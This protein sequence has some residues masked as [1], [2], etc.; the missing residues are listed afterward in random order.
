MRILHII[1][2]IDISGGGPSKSVSDLAFTQAM[3]GVKATIFTN[4]SAN[5]YLKE[6]P[7]PNLQLVF[8]KVKP[9]KKALKAILNREKFD[10]LHGHGMWQMPVHQ[11]AQLAKKKDIPTII[12]PR[13]MLEP[14]ALNA[15]KWKKKLAMELYQKKD[16]KN[17]ACIHATAQMEA[18]NIRNLGFKNPIAVIPNGIDLAE[19]PIPVKKEKKEKYTLLFLSR[20]HPKKGIELLIEAWQNLDK[21]LRQNWQI[22]IAGNGEETYIASLQKLINNTGLNHEIHIIGPQ[23]GK[24]KLAAYHRADLFVLPTYSENFGIVVAEALACGLPVITTKGTPWGELNTHNA[25]WWI[26]IGAAPLVE[27]LKKALQIS[28]TKRLQMGQNGRQLVERK[29]SIDAVA[30]K[31]IELY[32]WV[33]GDREKP[34]FV[35]T[36]NK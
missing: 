25:G 8:V 4:N 35:F 18:D 1:F 3:N 27:T 19:F 34:E 10:L 5:P 32:R 6:S 23:F 20:I 15:G 29:Y 24:A 17:A 16:L 11:M 7:H 26:D 31:M 33:L 28:E 21:T 14:W 36:T 13:G 12:T 22:E 2:S 9:F 30:I